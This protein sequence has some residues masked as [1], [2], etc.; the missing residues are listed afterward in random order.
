MKKKA[1]NSDSESES[2]DEDDSVDEYIEKSK[3]CF[4]IC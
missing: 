4:H 3:S 1:A 2:S